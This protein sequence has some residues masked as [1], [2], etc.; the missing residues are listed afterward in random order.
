MGAAKART[1]ESTAEGVAGPVAALVAKYKKST[2]GS[3]AAPTPARQPEPPT[4]TPDVPDVVGLFAWPKKPR[5]VWAAA[6]AAITGQPEAPRT[7][8]ARRP[9]APATSA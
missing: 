8:H 7:F 5:T 1:T 2:G 3:P 4:A 9:S 6:K